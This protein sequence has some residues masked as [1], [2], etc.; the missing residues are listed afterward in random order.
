MGNKDDRLARR[1][2]VVQNLE[3]ILRLLRREYRGRLVKDD[4]V[5]A[6]HQNLDNLNTLGLADG[7]LTHPAVKRNF[8]LILIDILLNRLSGRVEI[9][10]ES[11]LRLKPENGVLQHRKFPDQHKLLMHHADPML[12]RSLRRQVRYFLPFHPDHAAVNRIHAV[13]QL[14]HCGF[15]RTVFSDQRVNLALF[16]GELPVVDCRH[17]T[18]GFHDVMHLYDILTHAFTS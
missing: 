11:L 9:D 8:H 2:Q 14:H 16:Q 1:L 10:S 12:D 17:M 18:E 15:T 5:R 4:R 3:E 7:N 13:Q 6:A